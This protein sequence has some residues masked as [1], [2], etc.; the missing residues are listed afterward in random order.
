MYN[1]LGLKFK[2]DNLDMVDNDQIDNCLREMKKFF[3]FTKSIISFLDDHPNDK[4]TLFFVSGQD[5]IDGRGIT[6]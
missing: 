5:T 1:T 2:S 6:I 3:T 4:S